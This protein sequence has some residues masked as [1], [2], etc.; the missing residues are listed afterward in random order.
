MTK[1]AVTAALEKMGFGIAHSRRVPRSDEVRFYV[2]VL[3]PELRN[4]TEFR[5]T[6]GDTMVS[7]F[8]QVQSPTS[9]RTTDRF[10]AAFEIEA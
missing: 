10:V 1:Q 8:E 4:I 7:A 3:H 5:W 2:A 9:F 6:P